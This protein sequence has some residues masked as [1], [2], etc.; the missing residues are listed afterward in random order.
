[1]HKLAPPV[2]PELFR[3]TISDE[4]SLRMC[5]L[6]ALGTILNSPLGATPDVSEELG[7]LFLATESSRANATVID[8]LTGFLKSPLD[9]V[10]AATFNFLQGLAHYSWSVPAFASHAGFLEF[11]TDRAL[12]RTKQAKEWQF[13]VVRA[14]ASNETAFSAAFGVDNLKKVKQFMDQGPFYSPPGVVLQWEKQD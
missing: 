13:S 5:S 3:L 14:L 4:I 1:M 11:I 6:N 9:E 2:F 10:V 12:G 7:K 8:L